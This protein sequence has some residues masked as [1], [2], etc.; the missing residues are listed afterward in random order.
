MMISFHQRA[1]SFQQSGFYIGIARVNYYDTDI[2]GYLIVV[3]RTERGLTC[4]RH[5]SMV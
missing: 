5:S 3:T 2:V 4:C 1:S